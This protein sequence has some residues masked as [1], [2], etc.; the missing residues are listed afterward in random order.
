M[1]L[2]MPLSTGAEHI[3]SSKHIG[4]AIMETDLRTDQFCGSLVCVVILESTCI[5][6]EPSGTLV[7]RVCTIQSGRMGLRKGR[8]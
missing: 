8:A 4:S 3:L 2:S 6:L 1:A 5:Y 7:T